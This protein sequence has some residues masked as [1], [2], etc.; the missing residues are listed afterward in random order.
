MSDLHFSHTNIAMAT[1]E[2]T[3]RTIV[4]DRDTDTFGSG[5]SYPAAL[6]DLAGNYDDEYCKEQNE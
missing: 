6:M 2:T 4:W 1:N 3:G 5:F